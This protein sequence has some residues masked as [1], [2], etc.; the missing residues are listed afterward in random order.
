MCKYGLLH[1]DYYGRSPSFSFYSLSVLTFSLGACALF[2]ASYPAED[3][4]IVPGRLSQ[5]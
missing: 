2:L 3:A 4:Y 1:I 5:K